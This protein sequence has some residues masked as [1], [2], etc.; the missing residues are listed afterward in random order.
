LSDKSA[1]VDRPALVQNPQ[2]ALRA[3]TNFASHFN[4]IWV[5]QIA[6]EKYTAFP[7]PKSMSSSRHPAS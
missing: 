4:V 6:W 7:F 5:V 2:M 1:S 3:K